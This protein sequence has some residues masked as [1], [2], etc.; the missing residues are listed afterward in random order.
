MSH[1]A[2]IAPP[3]AGHFWA[4]EALAECL[5]MRGHRVTFVQQEDARALLR[6][7]HVEFA[8]LGQASHPPGSL[9]TVISHAGHPGAPFGLPPRDSLHQCLSPFAQISQ[10]LAG[11]DFPR[12]EAPAHF[13]PVGPLRSP[14]QGTAPLDLP[15]APGRPFVFASLGTLQGGR[16]GLFR[17]M[18]AACRDLDLQLLL[19]HCGRL[20]PGQVRALHAAGATWV[21]DFAPQCAALAQADVAITH[22]GLN[23][24][25]DALVAGTPMLA[26]PI[27]FN[28]PAIAARVV[29]A[30]AGLRASPL[31]AQRSTLRRLL[32]R[33]LDEPAFA[34]HATRI[35]AEA[36]QAGGAERAA[37]IVE[38]VLKSGRPVLHAAA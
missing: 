10:T 29:Y 23:T 32:R 28:Q 11:F 4:L 36:R 12:Q 22:A 37:D 5:I 9:A 13:H 18:A 14:N 31:L 26:L 24:V 38:A 1:F 17:R 19:A 34:E 16:F 15:V 30:G 21:T 2:V 8:A 25:L 3:F 33:L 7:P 6:Q 35:G 27:A 20:D